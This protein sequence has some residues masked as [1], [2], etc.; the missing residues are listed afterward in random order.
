M[1]LEFFN[2]D[3]AYSDDILLY[4]CVLKSSGTGFHRQSHPCHWLDSKQNQILKC[5]TLPPSG[6][7]VRLVSASMASPHSFMC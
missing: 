5:W 1:Y 4:V 2:T 6:G 3:F 7:A